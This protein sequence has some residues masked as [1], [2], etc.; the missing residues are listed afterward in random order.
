MF[1]ATTTHLHLGV[2]DADSSAAFYEALFGVRPERLAGGQAVFAL[3]SPPL[4]LT[5]EKRHRRGAAPRRTTGP[6]FDLIVT[7]PEHVGDAALAL[8]R[9]G[10]R[11][12]LED[13]GIE[14]RDP[15]GNAWRIRFVPSA[16]SRAVVR[17]A[18]GEESP[19]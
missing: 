2:D 5:L 19:R 17:R 3:D 9:A 15:D 10:V 12:R 8:R 6:G 13:R 18:E 11:L 14:A 16:K 7:E 4:V 1:A